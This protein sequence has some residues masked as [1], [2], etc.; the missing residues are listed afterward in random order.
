MEWS[1]DEEDEGDSAQSEETRKGTDGGDHASGKGDA[2]SGAGH[3]DDKAAK[4]LQRA[5]GRALVS[6]LVERVTKS[7]PP[8]A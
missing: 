2:S 5:R 7:Q 8:S 6:V 3:S 1:H 4:R